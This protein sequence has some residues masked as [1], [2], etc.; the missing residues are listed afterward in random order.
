MHARELECKVTDT[1]SLQ[2]ARTVLDCIDIETS[3]VQIYR[4]WRSSACSLQD[5]PGCSAEKRSTILEPIQFT[6][7]IRRNVSQ[8]TVAYPNVDIVVA[9]DTIMV[10]GR[11]LWEWPGVWSGDFFYNFT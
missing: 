6:A 4:K 5:Q 11:V 2:S 3:S 7:H 10:R 8:P 1:I 9:L